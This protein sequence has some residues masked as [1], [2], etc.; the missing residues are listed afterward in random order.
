MAGDPHWASVKYLNHC[1][2]PDGSR[3]ATDSSMSAHAITFTGSTS[4]ISTT[5]PLMDTSSYYAP[6]G[7]H[8]GMSSPDSD[9]WSL[10][11]GEFTV[12]CMFKPDA[13]G[14]PQALVGQWFTGRGGQRS[15]SLLLSSSDELRLWYSTTGSNF[16]ALDTPSGMIVGQTYSVAMDRDASGDVRLYVDGAML[17]KAN[18]PDSFFVSDAKM[19]VGDREDGDEDIR[20]RMDE[21]RIT[22]G[23]ARYASDSGY[24]IATEAFPD[25]PVTAVP[26]IIIN[27]L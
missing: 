27:T 4:E 6:D 9:D 15:W 25:G 13:L 20:G 26:R 21:I 19:V 22:K 2:G 8:S 12:E 24:T 17:I 1:E 7:S 10:G 16:P 3:A 11:A 23:V 5:D 14:I 18:I